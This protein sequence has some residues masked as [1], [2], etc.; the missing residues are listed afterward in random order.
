MTM[1]KFTLFAMAVIISAFCA[2]AQQT[3]NNPKDANGFYI[4]KWDC[5]NETFAAANDFEVDET[6]TFAVDVTGTPW[7]EWLKETPTAAGATRSLAFNKWTGF[8]DVNGDS[9]RLKQIKG[10]V[11]GATWNI[12]QLATTLDVAK[13][14]EQGAQ[15]YVYGQLFGFE[16][17]SD[18]PGAGW[19]MWPSTVA[20]GSNVD[21]GT[22]SGATFITLPYTGT[23]TSAEFY[24]DD[25]GNELFGTNYPIKG[26]APACAVSTGVE[27]IIS[28]DLPVS[29]YEY[30]N[31]QGAKLVK[32]PEEGLF[33]EKAIRIDGSFSTKKILKTVK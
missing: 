4:V 6:F 22:E 20:V 9:H 12:M 26:Y 10:N 30:Y 16:Y 19:W 27:N 18:N 21:P 29:S 17:T 13:A 5:A 15:T 32:E 11:Y 3:V 31:L 33:I 14:T 25:Y 28:S 24:N 8:G 7:E 1:K 2:T 23:K